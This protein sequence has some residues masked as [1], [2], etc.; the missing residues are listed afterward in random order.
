MFGDAE[1]EVLE[2]GG[3]ASEETDAPDA[4]GFGLIE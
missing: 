2:E 3:D 1:A 4:A